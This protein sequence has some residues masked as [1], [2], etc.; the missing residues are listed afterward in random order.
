MRSTQTVVEVSNDGGSTWQQSLVPTNGE[1]VA[2]ISCSSSSTCMVTGS[3]STGIGTSIF[4]TADGGR[5][6][7][8]SPLP[9][10]RAKASQ[11][12]RSRAGTRA[13]VSSS[14]KGPGPG[15]LGIG[16]VSYSTTNGGQSWSKS[17]VPGTFRPSALDCLSNG[18]CLAVG[19]APSAYQVTDPATQMI[20]DS[21]VIYSG[22]GGATWS[23]GVV[24]AGGDG[25][26]GEGII[27]LSC[28]DSLHCDAIET[29]PIPLILGRP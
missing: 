10:R 1:S 24:P 17:N 2:A 4:T 26:I 9:C 20:N 19:Y 8:T 14:K 25:I 16:Y 5:T 6:W 28:S 3:S 12:H 11:P 7:T 29:R 18:S 22:D 15:G 21:A 23:A 27:E 13:R